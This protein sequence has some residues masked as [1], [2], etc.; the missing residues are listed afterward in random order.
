M[1][2]LEQMAEEAGFGELRAYLTAASDGSMSRNNSETLAEELLLAL[3]GVQRRFAAL[4]AERC[5]EVAIATAAQDPDTRF[6]D[7]EHWLA[8]ASEAIIAE[9]PKP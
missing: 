6:N 8:K 5:A 2:T 4:V 9:F 3:G 1:K 7:T